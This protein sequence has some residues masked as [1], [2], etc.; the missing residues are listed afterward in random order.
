MSLGGLE[1]EKVEGTGRAL[2]LWESRT[3]SGQRYEEW[4]QNNQLKSLGFGQ[5][6]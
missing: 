4:G 6:K 3:V 5:V 1:P 2:L